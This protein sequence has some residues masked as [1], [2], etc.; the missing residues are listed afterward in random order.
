MTTLPKPDVSAEVAPSPDGTK[1]GATVTVT[2][3]GK[4]RSWVGEG[5]T[6]SEAV[7]GMVEKMLDDR[8]TGEFM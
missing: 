3:D 2:R 7:K 8:K 5:N 4:S 1:T 6:A